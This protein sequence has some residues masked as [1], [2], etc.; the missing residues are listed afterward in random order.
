MLCISAAQAKTIKIGSRDFPESV[1]VAEILSSAI[2]A[3]TEHQVERRFHLGGVKICLDAMNNGRLDIY[4]DYS[5]SLLHN[6]L[7]EKEASEYLDDYLRKSLQQDYG[8]KL[9]DRLGFDNNFVLVTTRELA[10]KFKLKTIS[11]LKKYQDKLRIG[12]KHSFFKRPDGYLQLQKAYDLDFKDIK[13]LEYNMALMQLK[14][15]RLDVIDAFST[16][17]RLY[18]DDLVVLKDDRNALLAYDSIYVYQDDLDD[19]LKEVFRALSSSL[20]NEKI[21]E[22]N[23]KVMAGES[24]KS[25]AES[26]LAEL[27][28]SPQAKSSELSKFEQ[29]FAML[30]RALKEH[31]FLSF[32][33]IFFASIIGI[34]LGVLICYQP[35]LAQIVLTLS[36]VAQVIPSLALLALLIPVFG[37]GFYSALAA[38]F[39]YALLPIVQNTYSGIKTIEDKYIELAQSL[40][41]S[42]IEIL[43]KV[44]LPMAAKSIKA[45]LQTSAVICVGAATLATFVGAG[46]LGDLIKAGIDLNSNYMI[47]LG[48]VPAALLALLIHYSLEFKLR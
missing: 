11:D 4:P 14:E 21:L 47:L 39:I 10:D 38:L 19:E 18:D 5:G 29:D 40:A 41:L 43:F 32:T 31:I 30:I 7:G 8:L 45:G 22:L 25:V 1:L 9:T 37:L 46:G 2:E 42:E 16:D 23:Q 44:K 6:V 20:T 33:A 36:S 17:A 12:L 3:K 28:F 24:Y 15:R 27:D 34:L 35:L 26:F 13:L 48:A